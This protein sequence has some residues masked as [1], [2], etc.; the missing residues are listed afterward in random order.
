MADTSTKS[1]TA[2]DDPTAGWVSSADVV[3]DLDTTVLDDSIN[4]VKQPTE[5]SLKEAD[6]H[7]EPT[8][9]DTAEGDDEPV[10]TN[11]PGRIVQRLA[12]GAGAHEPVNDPKIGT[13][14]RPHPNLI[15]E[16]SATPSEK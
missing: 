6:K 4:P 2:A 5:G 3:K 9:L 15:A 11:K 7:S 12:V 16:A 1:S 10:R 8:G 13:D 14:G